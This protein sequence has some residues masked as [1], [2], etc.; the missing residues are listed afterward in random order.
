MEFRILGPLEVREDGRIVL[1]GGTKQRAV[2]ALLV[3]NANRVVSTDRLIDHVWG[4]DPP[5][6]AVTALQGHVSALR[7][8]LGSDV[9][10]T[11][12]PGYVLHAD[13]AQIDIGRFDELRAEAR[14]AL[15]E[16][17]PGAAAGKLRAALALWRGEALAD[18][19]FE[20]F[21]QEESARLEDLR[22]ATLEDRIEADLVL[23][24]DA[25]LV[26]ELEGLV[27]ANPL[28]ERLRAQ[29]MLALYRSGRQA[30]AL[31][32]YGRARQ[33][34]V[35]ELGI[36]PG[37]VLRD[38][39]RRI[40]AQDPTLDIER[41]AVTPA[42]RRKATRQLAIFGAVIVAAGA[43]TVTL[44]QTAFDATERT[45]VRPNSTRPGTQSSKRSPLS[46]TPVQS[47]S[48]RTRF[49]SSTAAAKHFPASMR[50]RGGSFIRRE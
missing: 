22:L 23:G 24:R 49:G 30:E 44:I 27:A 45:V 26:S 9:I 11:R 3:L 20:P 42:P 32:A 31:D 29:L 15:A 21:A 10:T 37:P 40:L 5:A 47:P 13:P 2:L 1:L 33:R 43:V 12:Q 4:D 17:D 19:V 6:T 41:R 25:E 8:A 16:G 34:F 35:S 14:A 50:A 7:K 46:A 18:I 48:A 36:E 39:E 38:L 28:R